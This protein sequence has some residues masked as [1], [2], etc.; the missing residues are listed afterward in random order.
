MTIDE[1]AP[2]TNA[3]GSAIVGASLGDAFLWTSEAR[4]VQFVHDLLPAALIEGW[5]LL[6][7]TG[8]SDDG[9]VIVGNGIDPEGSPRAWRAVLGPS[10]SVDPQ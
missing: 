9:Q 6:N 10:C 1:T 4:T 3:A 7:A 5:T 2:R 8:I